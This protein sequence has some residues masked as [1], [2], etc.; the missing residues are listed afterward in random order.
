MLGGDD[1]DLLVGGEGHDL[2]TGGA[3]RDIFALSPSPYESGTFEW[4]LDWDVITDFDASNNGDFIG[5]SNEITFSNLSF[6]EI[7]FT[8]HRLD[9]VPSSG[10]A[11][12]VPAT[13][14][15]LAVVEGKT[16]PELQ[17]EHL[18]RAFQ[19]SDLITL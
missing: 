13:G 19:S 11:I 17:N 2:V 16:I 3:G 12:S 1:D 8:P 15:L 14:E 10:V 9:G 4:A 6:E 18:Y 5:L 7:D